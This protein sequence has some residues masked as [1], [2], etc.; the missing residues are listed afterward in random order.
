MLFTRALRGRGKFV[1]WAPPTKTLERKNIFA[2]ASGL[3]GNAHKNFGYATPPP[4]PEHKTADWRAMPALRNQ[5]AHTFWFF[6]S[7]S[8]CALTADLLYFSSEK[9]AGS[10]RPTESKP[11]HNTMNWRA[12]PVTK[13]ITKLRG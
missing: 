4:E 13:S 7:F 10:A 1:G 2:D 3:A 12:M 6:F 9:L 8:S 5:S 11:E